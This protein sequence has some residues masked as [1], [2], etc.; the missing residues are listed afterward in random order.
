VDPHPRG[1]LDNRLNRLW[2][3]PWSTF[4]RKTWSKRARNSG[5]QEPSLA[6]EKA[7]LGRDSFPR[8]SPLQRRGRRFEP[9]TA[10]DAKEQVNRHF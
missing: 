10:L 2:S 1:T 9:V 5:K 4:N 7:L 8:Q 6:C 3:T